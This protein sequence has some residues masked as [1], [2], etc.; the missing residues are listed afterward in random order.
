MR[1]WGGDAKLRS[2][3][4]MRTVAVVALAMTATLASAPTAGLP[5]A[6]A[7]PAQPPNVLIVITDDQRSDTME[8]LPQTRQFF[9][10]GG[11]AYENAYAT[12]P[13]C[14]PSRASIFTGRFVHNHR[15]INT[16]TAERLNHSSTLEAYLEN[17]G[18]RTA[19]TGK[20]LNLWNIRSDPPHFDRWAIFNDDYGVDGYRNE[21]WNVNGSVRKIAGYTTTVVGDQAIQFLDGFENSDSQPWLLYVFPFAPHSPYTPHDK[22]AEADVPAWDKNPAMTERDLSDKPRWVRQQQIPMRE[23]RHT[24]T[25]QLRTLMSVDDLMARLTAQL[26]QMQE[27][28]N[29]MVFFSSDNGYMWH[30]HGLTAKRAPYAPSVRIPFLFRYDAANLTS[31]D[32]TTP[33]ANID[34]AP[35]A[36]EAAGV[37]PDQDRPMDGR[38]LLTGP[39]R[40][41]MLLEYF[42]EM[43]VPTWASTVTDEMQYVEYY[44]NNG[45]TITFKEFYRLDDD[46]YQLRNILKDGT[47]SN[48]PSAS[49]KNAMHQQLD[50]DRNCRG[51]SCP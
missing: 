29:T 51:A 30:E 31:I 43:G 17:A 6:A 22:Y 12:T 3:I 20:Y 21:Q 18:Y 11:V 9:D 4:S 49:E 46:P 24:R 32:P 44:A 2:L 27:T 40:T 13:L 10:T 35:T 26:D 37:P 36:L 8:V 5:D 19:I 23:A 50:D 1:Q 41:R 45:T 42:V 7:Q 48:D 39:P 47:A 25:H 16:E 38:S 33:V 15:V 34:L 14:C 28:S